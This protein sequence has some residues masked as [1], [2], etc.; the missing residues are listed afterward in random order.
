MHKKIYTQ[1]TKTVGDIDVLDRAAAHLRSMAPHI[2]DRLTATLLDEV[3]KELTWERGRWPGKITMHW[4][5]AAF[6]RVV[7]GEPENDVM[8]DYGYRREAE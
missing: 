2:R 7:A 8:A 3:C 1:T 6:D 4:L 5:R